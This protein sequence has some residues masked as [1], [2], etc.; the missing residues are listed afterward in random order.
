VK[1]EKMTIYYA[2]KD[3]KVKVDSPVAI[4]QSP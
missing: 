1:G 3:G 4:G 2:L